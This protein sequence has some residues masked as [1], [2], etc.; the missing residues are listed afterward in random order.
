MTQRK[1]IIVSVTNDLC[2]DQRVH[3]VCSSLQQNGYQV[4]LVGRRQ[5]ASPKLAERPYQTKRFFLF[6]NKGPLFYLNYNLHL[7]FF[8]LFKRFD[9]LLSNDLDSLLANFWASKLKSKDLVYDSHEYFTEVPE[10]INRPKVQSIWRSIEASILPKVKYAYTVSQKIAEVY[11][12]T[13]GIQMKV[14]RNF[15]FV[16]YQLQNIEKTDSIILYQGALNVGRGLEELVVAM[17]FV[18]NGRLMIAGAGDIE[19]ELHELVKNLK[20]E[21]KVEFLGRLS[22]LDLFQI[23]QQAKLGVSLEKDMGLN[24]KYAVPNKIFDYIHAG[25][26]VL[27]SPLVEVVDLLSSFL[28]GET[29]IN[30]EPISIAAQ[31]DSMLNSENRELWEKECE[32]ASHEFNW[33]NEE[34]KLLELF[35]QIG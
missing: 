4:L 25:V 33:E 3:K 9:I 22:L 29:L 31:I 21:N 7:F 8:L 13:Y 30:H 18:K 10:L 2:T 5:K 1:K 23:T 17:Q 12:E 16:K 6:F 34:K 24:Y 27:F 32:R 28:I 35:K 26:P 19:F 14:I 11:N 20:L 15:P